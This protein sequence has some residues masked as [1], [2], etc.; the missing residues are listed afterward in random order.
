MILIGN[1]HDPFCS[2]EIVKTQNDV[3]CAAT[4]CFKIYII[5]KN[6]F[7]VGYLLL[8]SGRFCDAEFHGLSCWPATLAGTTAIVPCFSELNGVKYDVSGKFWGLKH[9]LYVILMHIYKIYYT[10]IQI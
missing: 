2:E 1:C 7:I 6:V 5:F 4:K 3:K 9:F 8:V 10:S